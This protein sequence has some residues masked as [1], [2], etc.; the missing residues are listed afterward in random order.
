VN[1]E[2]DET[3]ASELKEMMIGMMKEAWWYGSSDTVDC[4]ANMRP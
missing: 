1:S 3:P 2:G 4:I